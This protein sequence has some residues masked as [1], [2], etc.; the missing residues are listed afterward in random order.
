MSNQVVIIGAG[1]G[2][3]SAACYLAKAG[4]SVTVLEKNGQP[5]GRAMIMKQKGFLF[6]LGPS[7][8]MM[9]DVFDDFFAD[10]GKSTK[11]YYELKQL[12]P[13]YTVFTEKNTHRVPKAPAVYKLFE[14]IE[15]G[16]SKSLQQL[17]RRTKHEYEQIREYILERPQLGLHENLNKPALQLLTN[18]EL[19]RSY[20]ARIKKIR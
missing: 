9:P 17:L 20:H 1:F 14:S 5:G 12:E 7:W 18:P 11:D 8:Y 3:L 4:F 19:V 15:P 2:G 10:F 16:S 6:D 13:S